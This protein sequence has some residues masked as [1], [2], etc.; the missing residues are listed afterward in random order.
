[1]RAL[2][3]VLVQ[4]ACV[5]ATPKPVSIEPDDATLLRLRLTAARE[6]GCETVTLSKQAWRDKSGTYAAAGCGFDVTYLVACDAPDRC[7]F[8]RY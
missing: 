8:T 5:H 7:G 4:A 2:A 1:M 6:L 3:L